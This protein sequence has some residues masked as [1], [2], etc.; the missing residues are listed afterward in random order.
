M[1]EIVD[2]LVKAQDKFAVPPKNKPKTVQ[3]LRRAI[4]ELAS[5]EN[6]K[7]PVERRVTQ[8]DIETVAARSLNNTAGLE[9]STR[10]FV[11]YKD[12]ASFVSLATT[13]K[14]SGRAELN[15]DLLPIGHPLS[16]RAHAMTAS[17]YRE[18]RARWIAADPRIDESSRGIVA[19]AY[20]Y[21]P[22]SVEGQHARARLASLPEGSVPV[23]HLI[24]A[25]LTSITAAFGDGN[26]RAARSARARLQRRDRKGRFAEQGGGMQF[27][28]RTSSN[29]I[30]SVVGK[31]AGNSNTSDGFHVE[32]LGD[33]NLPD[34]IYDV[35]ASRTE[36]IK[37]IIPGDGSNPDVRLPSGVEAVDQDSIT[38]VDSPAGW[39]LRSSKQEGESG[40]DRVYESADGYIVEQWDA[41][42]FKQQDVNAAI[43]Y[44]AGLRDEVPPS[45]KPGEI[46]S[47]VDRDGNKEGKAKLSAKNP[48]NVLYRDKTDLTDKQAVG[49]SQSWSQTQDFAAD[50]EAKF[51]DYY[52]EAKKFKESSGETPPL[53]DLPKEEKPAA[54][55]F[56]EENS[57]T[58]DEIRSNLEQGLDPF[59]NK[60][61]EGWT[62]ELNEDA[63]SPS[64]T[65]KIKRQDAVSYT[66]EKQGYTEKASH[67]A[68]GR[69]VTDKSNIAVDDWNKLSER[70]EKNAD[71]DI[72]NRRETA[73][74]FLAPY[75]E[76]GSIRK[77]LDSGA[78]SEDVLAEL[79][80]N[81]KWRADKN[82]FDTRGFVD[83]PSAA[84]ESKWK[85][86][87]KGLNA[88][89]NFPGPDDEKIA[90]LPSETG[91]SSIK[92]NIQ[93]GIPNSGD[94]R[95]GM[96]YELDLYESKLTSGKTDGS[97]YGI[98]RM[99]V[100]G[101]TYPNR[102][103]LKEAGFKYKPDT[104]TW[105]KSYLG[106]VFKADS[107]NQDLLD[108]NP[109]ENLARDLERFSAVP[110]APEVSES[111][112][113]PETKSADIEW[114]VPENAF[115]L[116]NPESYTPEGR[117]DE[118][119][120][121]F[122]DDPKVLANKFSEQ[123]LKDALAQA[124]L[125][126]KDFAAEF[127]DE[128]I[129]LDGDDD[130]E[131]PKKSKPG[132]KKKKPALTKKASGYG[133]LDFAYGD[134]NVAAEAL[135]LALKEQGA[136]ADM[137]TAQIYDIASGESK[138]VDQLNSLRSP[139]EVR[140][141]EPSAILDDFDEALEI[142][143]MNIEAS[144]PDAAAT[145]VA[146]IN[147]F[148]DNEETN[149]NIL[150][151]ADD[152]Y[153]SE[154]MLK[155]ASGDDLFVLLNKYVPYGTSD[156]P[157]EN[158]AY[159]ALH[160]V[161]LSADGGIT[162]PD[163]ET[164]FTK[165]IRK[166]LR[167]NSGV[168][169]TSED[170]KGMFDKYGYYPDLIKSKKAIIDG[171]ESIN[172]TDSKAGALYRLIAVAGKNNKSTLY[173][174]IQVPLN[175]EDLQTYTTKGNIISFDARSF[176]DYPQIAE[177][178]AGTFTKGNSE[179]A[180]IIFTMPA[181]L[182]KSLD[183]STVS[184]FVDEREHLGFGN[185]KVVDS[186]IDVDPNTGRTQAVVR[187]EAL[188][189]REEFA[190]TLRDSYD[191]FLIENKQVDLPDGYYEMS[192]DKFEPED[193]LEE[194]LTE[195]ESNQRILSSPSFISRIYSEEDLIKGFRES[196]EDGTG[197]VRLTDPETE[198]SFFADS[199]SVRDA[200]QI[201]GINTNDILEDIA[202]AG[203]NAETEDDGE[204]EPIEPEVNG[205]AEVLADAAAATGVYPA[206]YFK[207]IGDQLGSNEGGT[208]ED[209]DGDRYYI[210]NPKS[211]AQG[212]TEV[213]SSV[214]YE[215]LDVSV[216]QI[217]SVNSEER[218]AQGEPPQIS[219]KII[220][221]TVLADAELT[222]EVKKKI[223]EGF[224]VDAWL[225][226]WDVAG[227]VND[228]I[229]IDE[230]GTPYRVDLG[231]SLLYRAQGMP[232]GDMFGAEV[233]ELDTLRDPNM[234]P[235]SAALFGDMTEE[236]LV[237]SAEKLLGIDHSDIDY[238]VD[239]LV[240]DAPRAEK[241]KDVLKAR[242][243]Y[244]LERY[245][246][247]G[248]DTSLI[249]DNA[250]IDSGDG[251]DGGDLPERPSGENPGSDFA[252]YVED[253][254]RTN[255]EP[256]KDLEENLDDDDAAVVGSEFM[257]KMYDDAS[258]AFD[259]SR[260]IADNKPSSMSNEQFVD[261]A[262]AR[263]R[264]ILSD[265]A[266]S[267]IEERRALEDDEDLEV[268]FDKDTFVDSAAAKFKEL[269]EEEI[270]NMDGDGGD[271]DGDGDG[272]GPW[273]SNNSIEKPANGKTYDIILAEMDEG[274]I[275][276]GTPGLTEAQRV[277]NEANKLGIYVEESPEQTGL[278]FG[279]ERVVRFTFPD[280]KVSEELAKKLVG[281]APDEGDGILLSRV[282]GEEDWQQAIDDITGDGDGDGDGGGPGGTSP[283]PEP[284]QPTPSTPE[285][286]SEAPGNP[287]VT[288]DGVPIEIGMELV[289]K[290]T[291]EI[292]KVV[293][294]DKG[295]TGYVYVQSAN[296]NIKNKST[297]QLKSLDG[298]EQ[299]D[300]PEQLDPPLEA[301]SFPTG[302]SDN[303]Q[304]HALMVKKAL[305]L[306]GVEVDNGQA[307]EY[308]DLI[309]SEGIL[310]TPWSEA[311]YGDII[312]ALNAAKP[313]LDLPNIYDTQS[314][315]QLSVTDAK[316]QI[317]WLANN[318]AGELPDSEYSSYITL[319]DDADPLPSEVA[320]ALHK[321]KI[322]YTNLPNAA[323]TIVV[324][325]DVLGLQSAI[326]SLKPGDL[327]KIG[328]IGR[329]ATVIKGLNKDNYIQVQFIDDGTVGWRSA[330]KISGVGLVNPAGVATQSEDAAPPDWNISNFENVPPLQDVIA[331]V[332]S[333]VYKESAMRG[334]STLID[335]AD[336]ED[337][338]VRVMKMR[339]AEGKDILR[340]K[341]K[342][343][344]WSGA[345]YV[346]RLENIKEN[347]NQRDE[348]RKIENVSPF[349]QI[350]RSVIDENG[351]GTV[352][353]GEYSFE[354]N[355]ET[356][357]ITP[358]NF[359]DATIRFT[360]AIDRGYNGAT[361]AK[362][363]D[364]LVE[365]DVPID[366]TP[367][368][369]QEVLKAAGV[370]NPRP[371]TEEDARVLVENRLMSIFGGKT[372]PTE[373]PSGKERKDLLKKIEDVWGITPDKVIVSVGASGRIETRLSPEDAQK[374][375]DATGTRYLAH[376]LT[377]TT[378]LVST[379]Y[380]LIANIL[381]S[382]QAA[383]LSTTV[384]WT[385]GIGGEGQS[386]EQD[387]G[388]GGADYVFTTPF[389]ETSGPVEFP[390][391]GYNFV[392]NAA[393]MFERLDFYSNQTDE[394][395]RRYK[396]ADV[397]QG[398]QAGGYEVMFKHRIGF[399]ALEYI[400]V[401]SESRREELLE[402]LQ[403]RGITRVGDKS[404]EEL[405]IVTGR[406]TQFL[407][408]VNYV[409]GEGLE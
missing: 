408:K 219:S 265:I 16:S 225:A 176:A 342:L 273:G 230:S 202:S 401:T 393:K 86:F 116:T 369:I 396:S 277:V 253:L 280:A 106:K 208:F 329:E 73:N 133:Q 146:Q 352:L 213:L 157:L 196:I 373:N 7:V 115:R 366:A 12:V 144:R 376:D 272:D 169:P 266:D 221:G 375:V 340:I 182:G 383:L 326:A 158:Q 26:S 217:S 17:A 348:I 387:V 25:T 154:F 402:V 19:A 251:D 353:Q 281:S 259:L 163:S 140:A 288:S 80:E 252:D 284:D 282:E 258:S 343:T 96:K 32:V 274:A 137:I 71:A 263:M 120:P 285:V 392:F 10:F 117:I 21:L 239:S 374:I 244:I 105:S 131:A 379:Y 337:L 210:K 336:I 346:N 13:G 37:A 180:G 216:P 85:K 345:V 74:E 1:Y 287:Y 355:G 206:D 234:N 212:E 313:S 11:A 268:D 226:N 112:S 271:G 275:D 161:L 301:V 407:P 60:I 385:E 194:G 323:K 377:G 197:Q 88:V 147:E 56:E 138:N 317:V 8:R 405:V 293:K 243:N 220:E 136:D 6:A 306:A 44:N 297:N 184:P 167:N 363:F 394:F 324:K 193:I 315:P 174:G 398:A 57:Q 40:P 236:D 223:Q 90:E 20:M 127:I 390:T 14:G 189:P 178:F 61:A 381:S 378:T 31:F 92:G 200:L 309:D 15:C 109:D 5:Q 201:K 87:E 380:D 190:E 365:I 386:S 39:T 164:D 175:S 195:E 261:D 310:G 349:V 322:K 75:D 54:E 232:K 215:F 173:R 389:S 130:E 332:T 303:L 354:G 28:L 65:E 170:I 89:T 34:G 388:T 122:T 395:G 165:A 238:I 67:I 331:E 409:T 18:V 292:G 69:L 153:D 237:A 179:N 333:D 335:A 228:N 139:E 79:E 27:Y 46:T 191:N 256:A 304:V 66:R 76:D 114:A 49:I 249:A 38:K 63:L 404:I 222:P 300:K 68:D 47:V 121:D 22:D 188:S 269:L 113:A 123:S 382:P 70:F 143:K 172:D 62:P 270:D 334:A 186:R 218:D 132:P 33:A 242:R 344:S 241:L 211:K 371:S 30:K 320:D 50:D 124:L 260:D 246:L 52:E 3:S 276:D 240:D 149:I 128:L 229:I 308:R 305:F 254:S 361:N 255:A 119:S 358:L 81:E 166:G 296:G 141:Q 77:M 129:E 205:L 347:A 9:R 312:D 118:E 43:N 152:M 58:A 126:K 155:M 325:N 264:Q 245:G 286:P 364:N 134:E 98:R 72:S 171:E 278:A 177:K 29:A 168:E 257:E 356:Y 192:L 203:P 35:P 4:T 111:E 100:S 199:E 103:E 235:R 314:L 403:D 93:A 207:K 110:S 318:L 135:Y 328:E 159:Q 125:G 295:N 294:Y 198:D 319:A 156:D 360:R 82:D 247:L 327:V 97:I 248:D 104:K 94:L 384:R 53:F 185:Y 64:A 150:D 362:A 406:K 350:P 372:D 339:N 2:F 95:D 298:L 145:A 224:A 267:A 357:E 55:N 351:V 45:K 160:S 283:E 399:D 338:D 107:L 400:V 321:L 91:A 187:I 23:E 368:Q 42:N 231:G 341:Y 299:A 83:L 367:E 102:E 204:S 214:F 359:P 227:L 311:D 99:T 101:D 262:V 183:I 391:S 162:T 84:Q 289:H 209:P 250:R 233:T 78:S 302:D 142:G 307:M 24:N 330:G 36:A 48:L 148:V 279:D 370:S 291:G 290:K 51:D 316:S 59:G 151:L 181:G 108:E 397:I 41:G